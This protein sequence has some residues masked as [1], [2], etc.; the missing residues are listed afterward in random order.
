MKKFKILCF[1]LAAV[2]ALPFSAACGSRT[3]PNL[4][5]PGTDQPIEVDPTKEQI[6]VQVHFGGLGSDWITRLAAEW[7]ETNANYQVIPSARKISSATVEQ[8]I[9]LKLYSAYFTVDPGYMNL[10]YRDALEDLSD[11][12]EMKPDGADGRKIGEKMMEPELWKAASSKNGQGCYS[13]PLSEA[14][15]GM[16]YDHELLL[17]KGWMKKAEVSEKTAVE[18]QGIACE[19]GNDPLYGEVLIFRSSESYTNYNNGDIILSAGKDG[20]YGTYD[21]GQPETLADFEDLILT[22]NGNG[23]KP[24]LYTG[25]Y[26]DYT[27]NIIRSVFAQYSGMEEYNVYYTYDSKGKTVKI[28]GSN[29]SHLDNNGTIT[30][31]VI[32]IDNGYRA[33]SMEGAYQGLKFLNDYFNE[34]DFLHPGSRS[35]TLSHTQAQEYYVTGYQGIQGNPL[36][37]M[38]LEGSWWENEA[39]V[40]LNDIA[41]TDPARG[42]GKRDYRFML[43]PDLPDQKG[44]K[45]DGKGSVFAVQ[46]NG[47]FVVPKMDD[48]VKLAAL[49]DFLAYTLSDASLRKFTV[50]TG[51]A[52]PYK[53]SLTDAD[54]AEMSKFALN[55]FNLYMDTENVRMARPYLMISSAPINTTAKDSTY[56]FPFF[57]DAANVEPIAVLRQNGGNVNAA[58][59][60]LRKLYMPTSTSTVWSG[61]VQSAR[62]AGF[63]P[64]G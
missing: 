24:F 54:R 48:K 41:R 47:A 5:G 1:M 25:E 59:N 28:H 63:Y 14:F 30:D 35:S 2:L 49:K 34:D 8:E 26:L 17:E 31:E 4:G 39:R 32:T 58:F 18:A 19:T 46:D 55:S 52:R 33:F 6:Y 57:R 16:V 56:D 21:D 10:I 12:L 20:K 60:E 22:I 43:M 42:Y 15:M 64:I 53:Y 62:Q 7:N 36:T 9:G 27:N 37:A 23:V 61:Y 40:I 50:W 51:V 45:G 38:I 11:I 29:A 44:A 13:L 3:P